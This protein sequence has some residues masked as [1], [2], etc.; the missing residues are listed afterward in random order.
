MCAAV[1][2]A[3]TGLDVVVL[4][5]RQVGAGATGRSSAKVS[6]LHELH[7]SNIA[8]RDGA[9]VARQYID[10]NTAGFDWIAQQVDTTQIDCDWETKTAVTY[11]TERSNIHRV[12]EE[13]RVLVAAGVDVSALDDDELD[14]MTERI[15]ALAHTRG[16]ASVVCATEGLKLSVAPRV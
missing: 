7:A 10:A 9:T 12:D 1:R 6:I 2:L 14:E 8:R 13:R 15:A 4:D 11:V 3:I 16:I 5:T